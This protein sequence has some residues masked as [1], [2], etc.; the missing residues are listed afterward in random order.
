MFTP[1][2]LEGTLVAPSNVGGAHWGGVAYDPASQ[3]VWISAP[4]ADGDN[5]VIHQFHV[6]VAGKG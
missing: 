5:P 6:K 4:N 1:P 3:R 2:S